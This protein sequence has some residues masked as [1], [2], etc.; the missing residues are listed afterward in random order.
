MTA[1]RSINIFYNITTIPDE[2]EEKGSGGGGKVG[3]K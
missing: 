2:L 3:E 1:Q